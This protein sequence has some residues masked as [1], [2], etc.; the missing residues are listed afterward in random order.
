MFCAQCGGA[1]AQ[2]PSGNFSFLEE[3][4]AKRC[5]N[6]EHFRR[7]CAV[8]DQLRTFTNAAAVFQALLKI[9]EDEQKL[10]AHEVELKTIQIKNKKV[11]WGFQPQMSDYCAAKASEGRFEICELKN[12]AGDCPDYT[13]K[14]SSPVD[15]DGCNYYVPDNPNPFPVPTG[16]A[17]ELYEKRLEAVD[18]QIAV[19]MQSLYH[20]KGMPVPGRQL[21][22]HGFCSYF[23]RALPYA[24]VHRD[25]K[26]KTDVVTPVSPIWEDLRKRGKI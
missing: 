23:G 14:A 19:E 2:S 25:C 10:R 24:N 11:E 20:R 13:R 15:C 6:C 16:E 18:A 22:V 4:G 5:S 12:E 8:S 21:L 3:R 17:T 26:N 1:I 7:V 9:Q